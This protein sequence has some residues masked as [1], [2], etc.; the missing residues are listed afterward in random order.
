MALGEPNEERERERENSEPFLIGCRDAV[1][2]N[3]LFSLVALH[4]GQFLVPDV[5]QTKFLLYC[6]NLLFRRKHTNFE[7]NLLGGV[8][9]IF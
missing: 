8:G 7:L 9:I 5:S 3:I 2:C 1:C 4:C 6:S